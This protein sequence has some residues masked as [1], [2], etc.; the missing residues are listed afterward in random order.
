MQERIKM[1]KVFYKPKGRS[2]VLID[3]ELYKEL[4]G[5]TKTPKK[6]T[7]KKEVKGDE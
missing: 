1:A 6:K 4:I 2:A 7:K 5:E 3:E